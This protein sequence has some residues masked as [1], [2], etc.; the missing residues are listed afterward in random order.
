ME[1]TE[2]FKPGEFVVLKFLLGLFSFVGLVENV[3]VIVV[4]LTSYILRDIPSNWF[5]LS[6]AIA[7]TLSCVCI[8]VCH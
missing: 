6:L 2:S 5:V 1:S 4:F 8:L 7:D 3:A